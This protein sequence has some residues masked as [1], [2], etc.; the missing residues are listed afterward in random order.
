MT[1]FG[2]R[3]RVSE[4]PSEEE[5]LKAMHDRLWVSHRVADFMIDDQDGI[6]L[7]AERLSKNPAAAEKLFETLVKKGGGEKAISAACLRA[8]EWERSNGPHVQNPAEFS[9]RE[10]QRQPAGGKR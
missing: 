1:V 6:N 9:A 4:G 8:A 5:I 7:L 10:L 3:E 2:C